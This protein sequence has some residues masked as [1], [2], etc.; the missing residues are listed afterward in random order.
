[1]KQ[2]KVQEGETV[3]SFSR[4]LGI[5]PFAL[6]KELMERG[7]FYTMRDRLSFAQMGLIARAHQFRLVV[8][9]GRCTDLPPVRMW[10]QARVVPAFPM[11][12]EKPELKGENSV[13]RIGQK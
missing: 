7:W 12:P 3:W 4:K 2:L 11:P 10:T 13:R 8:E 5:K 9:P 1:M 6:I